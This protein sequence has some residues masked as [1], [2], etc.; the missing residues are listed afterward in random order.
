MAK[1]ITVKI[2]LELFSQ[3]LS[4]QSFAKGKFTMGNQMLADM[5]QYV[6]KNISTLRQTGHVTRDNQ[7]LVWDT[8]YARAQFH[9]STG[10]PGWGPMQIYTTPGTGRRWDLKAKSLH[11]SKWPSVFI[12]GA[13]I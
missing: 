5:N 9:G 13:G 10:R 11:S 4:P 12:K 3:K 7:Y 8:V 1:T 6:P 2:D